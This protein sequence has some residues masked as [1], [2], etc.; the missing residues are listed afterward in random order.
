MKLV[1][2]MLATAVATSA[3][4]KVM[5]TTSR[6]GA[7]TITT[8]VDDISE[9]P[10]MHVP[11]VTREVRLEWQ[12]ADGRARFGLVDNGNNLTASYG[13]AE[14]MDNRLLCGTAGGGKIFQYSSE[15]GFEKQRKILEADWLM[16]LKNT[17]GKIVTDRQFAIYK[18][19]FEA[20]AAQFSAAVEKMKAAA[21]DQF[22]GWRRR[23]LSYKHVKDTWADFRCVRQSAKEN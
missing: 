8:T 11:L 4:A 16:S 19:Q 2:L 7:F 12:S 5:V 15:S 1:L 17:C 18:A 22:G 20:S 13:V 21:Q 6:V 10:I 23:C 14:P 3:E 9:T